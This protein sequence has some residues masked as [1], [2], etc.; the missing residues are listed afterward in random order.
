LPL[1]V[2]VI[3][4]KKPTEGVGEDAVRQLQQA[5]APFIGWVAHRV[6]GWKDQAD[7]KQLVSQ[8]NQHMQFVKLRLEVACYAKIDPRVKATANLA[9]CLSLAW[10][11]VCLGRKRQDR[12]A[13]PEIPRPKRDGQSGWDVALS[14]GVLLG[15]LVALVDA[16]FSKRADPRPPEGRRQDDGRLALVVR[17]SKGELQ[18]H[19]DCAG[20][21]KQPSPWASLLHLL[22]R[23]GVVLEDD[24]SGLR[25][26][27]P[28]AD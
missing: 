2:R 20:G 28:T 22:R 6:D 8:L 14:E 17:L 4:R 11:T 23:T 5:G 10:M 27:F 3:A 12:V 19:L 16:S 7:E 25:F 18:D 21:E 26:L 13:A 1:L 15:L 24:G 9:T